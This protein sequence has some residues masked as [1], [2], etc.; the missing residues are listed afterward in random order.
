MIMFHRGEPRSFPHSTAMTPISWPS[1]RVGDGYNHDCAV[2]LHTGDEY[3]RESAH[4]DPTVFLA[5]VR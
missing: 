1:T 2:G 5:H 3:V 4:S